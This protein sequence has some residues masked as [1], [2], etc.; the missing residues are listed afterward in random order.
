[1]INRKFSVLLS[2]YQK[3]SPQFLNSCLE[4]IHNQSLSPNEIVIVED[5]PLTEDLH[6]ILQ[7][8][9]NVFGKSL[10]TISLDKNLGLGKALA[11]GVKACQHEII[12]RMDADDLCFQDRFRKQISFLIANPDVDVVSSWIDEF[13]AD[14]SEIFATRRVPETNADILKFHRKRN[15]LN[16]MAVVFKRSKVIAAGSYTHMPYFEDYFLWS[17]M[18]KMKMKFYNIQESLVYARIGTDM[19]GR[20]HGLSYIQAEFNHY[21]AL[22]RIGFINSFEMIKMLAIRLPLRLIPKNILK[23]LYAKFIH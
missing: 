11:H 18:M 2:V 22:K 1:M 8:W 14:T 10:K 16:H 9:K 17:K 20:R 12:V 3:E 4:S 7:Q 15:A 19:I 5:G 23:W 13:I 6:A 21:V